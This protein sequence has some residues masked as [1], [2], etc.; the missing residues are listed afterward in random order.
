MRKQPIPAAQYIRV[1]TLGQASSLD[2]QRNA[3][4]RYADRWG[5]SITHT[6]QDLGKRGNTIK[7]RFDFQK[8]IYE[9]ITGKALIERSWSTMLLVGAVFRMSTRLVITSS[10]AGKPAC[11]C[12][13][14]LMS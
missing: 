10:F 1:S 5:F 14:V 8:L 13:F 6:F 2:I 12:I 9:V 7:G 4:E 11:P 3:I